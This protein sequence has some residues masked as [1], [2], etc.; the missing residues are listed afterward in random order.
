MSYGHLKF[1]EKK[2]G[3][4]FDYPPAGGRNFGKASSKILAGLDFLPARLWRGFS[5]RRV[6]GETFLSRKKNI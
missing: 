2:P 6:A 3:Q 1:V 4:N 5:P